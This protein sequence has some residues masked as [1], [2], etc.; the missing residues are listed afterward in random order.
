MKQAHVHGV[1][2]SPLALRHK[3]AVGNSAGVDQRSFY[4]Q[5]P[6]VFW[7]MKQTSVRGC[8]C[9]DHRKTC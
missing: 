1:R 3:S 2:I 8:K 9:N 5:N 7:P 6:D 4:S